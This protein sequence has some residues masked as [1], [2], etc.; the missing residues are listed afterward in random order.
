MNAVRRVAAALLVGALAV[1]AAPSASSAHSELVS[2][3]PAEGARPD[4]AVA[5]LTLVFE[6][7]IDPDL[8][9][10]VLAGGNGERVVGQPVV[11]DSVVTVPVSPVDVAGDYEVSYRVV[12]ADGHPVSGT[13][14]FTVSEASA[15]AARNLPAGGSPVVG[16]AD[17]G[18]VAGADPGLW[19]QDNA[20][21]LGLLVCAL[22]IIVASLVRRSRLRTADVTHG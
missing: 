20:A 4:A 10:V 9:D 5:T 2:S 12:A 13:Y 6:S 7:P 15:E 11:S 21:L 1:I 19:W 3:T 18:P 17:L 16:A 22:A 14:G 8:A